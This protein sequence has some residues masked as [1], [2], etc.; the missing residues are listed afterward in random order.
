MKKLL[1]LSAV[2][3]AAL[4]AGP[5]SA[6]QQP[7]APAPAQAPQMEIT[8]EIKDKFIDAYVDIMEIQMDYSEQLESVSDQAV[9]NSM[10][11]EAQTE[12]QEAVV[13]NELTIQQYNQII[14]MASTD[15]ELQQELQAAIEENS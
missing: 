13:D 8:P 14:Q 12:M 10:Q 3:T 1:T 11:Q 4:L 5:V 2:V 15:Q 7:A 6:Q 9:A